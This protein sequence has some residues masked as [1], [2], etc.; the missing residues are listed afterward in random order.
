[1]GQNFLFIKTWNKENSYI[2]YPGP[3]P[4]FLQSKKQKAKPLILKASEDVWLERK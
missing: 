2:L 3:L 4:S 1:M